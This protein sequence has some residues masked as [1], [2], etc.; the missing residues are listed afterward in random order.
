MM[1]SFQR[2]KRWV[3]D[4][5]RRQHPANCPKQK[6]AE[7]ELGDEIAWGEALQSVEKSIP[8][9]ET[10]R[11]TSIEALQISRSKRPVR[12]RSVEQKR[13][14]TDL[15]HAN[16]VHAIRS[17]KRCLHKIASTIYC[18]CLQVCCFRS[19]TDSIQQSSRCYSATLPAQHRR[20]DSV[21]SL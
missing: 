13:I 14:R 8:H 5:E 4:C 18:S 10:V 1:H 7:R 21:R 19:A 2:R 12:L 17:K 9:A 11:R 20:C 16:N 15:K 3:C 6:R